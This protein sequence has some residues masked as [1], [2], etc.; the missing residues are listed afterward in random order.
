MMLVEVEARR[1]RRDGAAVE[2]G[3]AVILAGVLEP[4][5]PEQSPR[6]GEEADGLDAHGELRIGHRDRPVLNEARIGEACGACETQEVVP[7]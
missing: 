6:G 2:H 7:V 5:Q 4:F 3:L 1:A